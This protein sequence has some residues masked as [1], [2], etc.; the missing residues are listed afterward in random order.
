VV[1]A[2]VSLRGGHEGREFRLRCLVLA[3]RVRGHEAYV[4]CT[5]EC[6][7]SFNGITDC[8]VYKL[9]CRVVAANGHI[10][11]SIALACNVGARFGAVTQGTFVRRG[12][13]VAFGYFAIV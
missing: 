1:W 10:L 2:H 3:S 5:I 8:S 11:A 7:S 9:T 13:P 4:F 6:P 12:E